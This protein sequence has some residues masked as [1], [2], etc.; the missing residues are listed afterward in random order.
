MPLNNFSF[1]YEGRWGRLFRSAQPDDHGASMLG[2]MF[3]DAVV[4]RLSHTGEGVLTAEQEQK[5]C[6]EA[7]C[8]SSATR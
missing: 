8:K 5:R 2:Q 6:T 4:I 3:D 7:C 1:V